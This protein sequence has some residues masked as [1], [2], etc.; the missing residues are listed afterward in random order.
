[1]VGRIG[2]GDF[3]VGIGGS[4]WKWPIQYEIGRF[5]IGPYEGAWAHKKHF[6]KTNKN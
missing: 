6:K 3:V 4:N 1:L 5:Y 2:S